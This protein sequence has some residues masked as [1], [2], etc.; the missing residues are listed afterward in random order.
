VCVCVCDRVSSILRGVFSPHSSI[1]LCVLCL[2]LV[3]LSVVCV[4]YLPH[5]R[6]PSEM[7]CVSLLHRTSSPCLPC[8]L[9]IDLTYLCLT[10]LC[11]TYV[12]LTYVC[13][14][15]GLLCLCCMRDLFAFC[16]IHLPH[17]CISFKRTCVSL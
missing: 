15:K 1:S 3:Y 17:V 11:L 8:V 2:C 4:T 6:V 16:V 5:L 12:S 9:S 14:L 13:L 7:T 10:Y